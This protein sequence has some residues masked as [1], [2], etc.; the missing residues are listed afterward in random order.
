[1]KLQISDTFIYTS[2]TQYKRAEHFISTLSYSLMLHASIG[3]F[4]RL[5]EME[6]S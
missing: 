1:M 3:H 6:A 4:H 5:N 2:L